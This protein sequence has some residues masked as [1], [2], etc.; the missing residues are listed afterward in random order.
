MGMVKEKCIEVTVKE[1]QGYLRLL[2]LSGNKEYQI[3]EKF[4]NK[5]TQMFTVFNLSVD[6]DN[7]FAVCYDQDDILLK[8]QDILSMF[9]KS[10]LMKIE[11]VQKYKFILCF[12]SKAEIYITAM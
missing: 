6:L 5:E 2:R 4:P 11:V 10:Q 12:K 1:L 7:E 8:R 3:T 9:L